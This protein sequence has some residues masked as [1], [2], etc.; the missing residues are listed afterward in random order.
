MPTQG[1]GIPKLASPAVFTL[2]LCFRH[3][4]ADETKPGMLEREDNERR[5]GQQVAQRQ[6]GA[7][8]SG[9][10]ACSECGVTVLA[11]LSSTVQAGWE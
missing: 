9:A 11:S 3:F 5:Q 10:V 6:A 2:S 7:L 1:G 8:T 4:T